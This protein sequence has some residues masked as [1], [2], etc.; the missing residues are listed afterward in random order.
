[1]LATES[2]SPALGST[3]GHWRGPK[4][5]GCHQVHVCQWHCNVSTKVPAAIGDKAPLYKVYTSDIPFQVNQ[6]PII[7]LHITGTLSMKV[8]GAA[9]PPLVQQNGVRQGCPLSPTLFGIFFDGLHGHLDRS[10]PHAGLQLGS[11]RWVSALVYADDVVLLSWTASG[12]QGLLDS[13]HAF[14]LGWG[15]TIS[16]SKTE[17]VVFNG[18]SGDTWRVGQH[19]LPRS[20]SFKSLGI[21]FHESGSMTEA[22]ARLLQNG[23]G[24]AARLAAKHK[25][26]MCDKS[27]PMMRRLFDA[28][29]RPTVSYECEVWAPACSPALVPQLKD[30]QNIQLSFFRN[31]CHLRKSVTPHII[32]REFAERPWLDSWWS[33]VLGFMRRL[34]LIVYRRPR[35]PT[36]MVGDTLAFMI[37]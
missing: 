29:V 8:G 25:A 31:L 20:A 24:A 17:V 9:G 32:F 1:M 5:V 21:V 10:L 2:V 4:D 12:L 6:A 37:L 27:F 35:S 30:M 13:M 18:S 22:L 16:P 36:K 28:V 33:M 26:L 7:L 34:S 23:K 3:G 14:C 19:V 15:L 11:G